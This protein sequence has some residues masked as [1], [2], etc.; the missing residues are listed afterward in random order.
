M[1]GTGSDALL[2]DQPWPSNFALPYRCLVCD[3]NGCRYVAH[4]YIL[5]LL[6]IHFSVLLEGLEKLVTGYVPDYYLNLNK[7]YSDA[8]IELV[9]EALPS[10]MISC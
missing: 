3:W 4:I 10:L 7:P 6:A 1:T 5:Q 2:H 9:S 8:A